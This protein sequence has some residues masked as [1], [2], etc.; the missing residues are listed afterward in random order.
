MA[1]LTSFDA[2]VLRHFVRDWE[3]WFDEGCH[4]AMSEYFAD[5]AR[6]VATGTPTIN[7]RAGVDRFI[8]ASSQWARESGT[9]HRVLLEEAESAGD[10]GYMRG[11]VALSAS[12][13]AEQT[14]V[15]CTTLWKRQPDGYWR[16]IEDISCAAPPR[17]LTA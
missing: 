4:G 8:R 11:T 5:D 14:T 6:L 17:G 16:L 2:D 1:G 13:A 15:R 7:G 10:L 9:R 3:R 12:D